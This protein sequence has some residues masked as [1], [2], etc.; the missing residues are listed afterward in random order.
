M[1]TS[2]LSDCCS[3]TITEG[4]DRVSSVSSWSTRNRTQTAE[5]DSVRKNP[6]LVVNF[7]FF[8]IYSLGGSP[9]KSILEISR[10]SSLYSFFILEDL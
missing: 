9:K 8:M 7:S 1:T 4:L 6:K 10:S 5:I 2:E 3:E